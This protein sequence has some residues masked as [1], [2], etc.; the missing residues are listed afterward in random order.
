MAKNTIVKE[1]WKD[2]LD[3]S[4]AKHTVSFSFEGTDYAID[5]NDKNRLAI[6]KALSPFI[7]A[8]RIV[9]KPKAFG[10]KTVSRRAAAKAASNGNGHGTGRIVDAGRVR[11]WA[12]ANGHNVSNRGRISSTVLAAYDAAQSVSA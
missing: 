8:G 12:T 11:E 7:E 3:G 1:E 5:V 4:N 10:S 6:T 9:V 2:D